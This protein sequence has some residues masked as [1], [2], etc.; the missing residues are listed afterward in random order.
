M[1]GEEKMKYKEINSFSEL[2]KML[3]ENFHSRIWN[4]SRDFH[5]FNNY[6]ETRY[7]FLV[8]YEGD[9]SNPIAL[10][11]YKSHLNE[12]D[13]IFSGKYE[14]VCFEVEEAYRY[15]GYGSKI[16]KYFKN[17][18]VNNSKLCGYSL[19][20]SVDFWIQLASMYDIEIYYRIYDEYEEYCNKFNVSS[21]DSMDDFCEVAD[22]ELLMFFEI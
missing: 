16:I 2:N 22:E 13:S 8:F 18:I 11:L 6:L 19:V 14:I 17:N 4:L 10:L 12:S 21:E 7:K 20:S 5:E 1:N 15:E 3:S 9:S